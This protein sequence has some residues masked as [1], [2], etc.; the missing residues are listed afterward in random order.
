M[1]HEHI[2][3][4]N[5]AELTPEPY[6]SGLRLQRFPA[7]V[8][9]ALAAN[10]HGMVTGKKASSIEIRF[11]T[12][13]PRTRLYV[14]NLQGAFPARIYRG[15]WLVREEPLREG[16]TTCIELSEPEEEAAE[17]FR[18]LSERHPDSFYFS[19]ML[20]RVVFDHQDILFEGLDTGENEVWPPTRDELPSRRW[21]AYGSSITHASPEGYVHVAAERLG[22]DVMNKGMAGACLCEPEMAAY[23]A[24]EDWDIATLE[25]GINMRATFPPKE[26]EA[27]A[28]HLIRT[29]HERNPGKPIG[30]INLYDNYATG[31]DTEAG[32]REAAYREILDKL[33]AGIGEPTVVRIPA[34]KV[35]DDFRCLSADFVHPTR[36]GHAR[37]GANL[38]DILSGM[39]G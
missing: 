7:S 28:G 25:L 15:N 2:E 9:S 11:R 23:L 12:D 27:R 26:F 39:V 30:V 13:S 18:E 21:L 22:W 8:R 14:K 19:P 1:I 20:W 29:L 35:M 36:T 31:T 24:V 10:T 33:V 4:W 3:F 16:A 37:M 38:A 34:R 6:Q 32:H 17:Q 5:A